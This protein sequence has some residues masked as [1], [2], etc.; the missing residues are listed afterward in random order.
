[1]IQQVRRV[2]FGE[3]ALELYPRGFFEERAD[4]IG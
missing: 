3:A 2:A 1:M 4:P